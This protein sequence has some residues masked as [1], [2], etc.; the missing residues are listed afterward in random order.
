M[1]STW[2]EGPDLPPRS[3]LFAQHEALAPMRSRVLRRAGIAHRGRTLDIGAGVGVSTGEL[4]RRA[5]GPVVA[6]DRRAD[7]LA[8]IAN[9][10]VERVHADATEMPF[11]DG[12]FEL[13]LAQCVFL[14]N[15]APARARIAAEIARVLGPGGVLVAIEPDHGAAMEHPETIAVGDVWCA[16]LERAGAEPRVGRMLPS[17]LALAGLSVRVELSP[18]PAPGDGSRFALLEGLPLSDAE[19]ARV[20]R[21]RAAEARLAPADAFVHVPFVFVTARATATAD[22]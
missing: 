6:L 15:D 12:S 14:W 2:D 17:E 21:A 8:S 9:D 1:P 5:R 11:A 19:R 18:E 20:E 16:A 4:V 3:V 22:S 13:V 10:T 7:A